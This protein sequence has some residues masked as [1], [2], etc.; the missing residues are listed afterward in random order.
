MPAFDPKETSRP[1]LE[2]LYPASLMPYRAFD[3]VIMASGTYGRAG[4]CTGRVAHAWVDPSFRALLLENCR[5]AC[6]ELG[7]P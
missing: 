7:S 3:Y 4:V 2:P 1:K 6:E 5:A